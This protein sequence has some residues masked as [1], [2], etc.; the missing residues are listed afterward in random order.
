M[1]IGGK[2]GD[3]FAGGGGTD[4]IKSKS[5]DDTINGSAGDD[6]IRAGHGDDEATGGSGDDVVDG[7]K[8]DD[9]LVYTFAD[10]V[11]S[12]DYY[13][14]GKGSDTLVLRMTAAEAAEHETEIADLKAWIS[15]NANVK[16][17]GSHGFNDAASSS[18]EHPVF[19]TSFGLTVRNFETLEVQVIGSGPAPAPEPAPEPAPALAPE[20][21]PE[22]AAEEIKVNI[23]ELP[24][25][26]AIPVS[27]TLKPGSSV[28]VSVDVEVTELPPKFDVFM[29]QDLSGSFYN[30]LPNVKALF[31]SLVESLS[32]T[33]D[34]AFGI[35]SFVDKT[36]APF[37]SATYGDYV[38]KTDKAIDTDTDAVQE[39]LDGLRT[40]WGWDWPESQLEALVQV[41]LRGEE[42]GFRDGAQKFVVLSTDAPPHVAGDYA[43]ASDGANNYDTVIDDEDY[44]DP[45]IVGDLLIAA[46]ITPIFAVTAPYIS[47]YQEL[48]DSWGV[49]NVVEL[50]YDSANIVDAITTGIK[51]AAIDLTVDISSDDYGYVAGM[52]PEV[53]A[54]AGPGIYTFDITLKIPSDAESYGS[55]ALTLT[56]PGYGEIALD[57]DI[58]GVDVTGDS[59]ADTL[60][61]DAGPNAIYGLAGDDKLDGGGGDDVIDGGTGDDVLTG[62]AGSD[63]FVFATGDGKDVITDFEAGDMLDLRRMT[64]VASEIEVL[65]FATTYVGADTVID[66]GDGDSVTLMGVAVED[67][68]G[69]VII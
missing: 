23:S 15:D 38:Y 30:D 55:D 60:V 66:F 7:G 54:D 27:V 49:G 37:G 39:A 28:T 31:P 57:I 62:G 44:P 8:G 58:V 1:F 11:G 22:A 6:W 10:N 12:T 9:R 59:A 40:Y 51:E 33:S 16:N 67:L 69:H 18:A 52:T 29:V 42:I 63:I 17:S 53:Y 41:A 36:V 46:G 56:I 64:S 34:V 24:P 4:I 19:E 13:D 5:G 32:V 14:G 65:A 21:A 26:E 20:A 45:A 61:G 50:A 47:V 43:T 3:D 2:E 25:G 35:G 68:D 48:V